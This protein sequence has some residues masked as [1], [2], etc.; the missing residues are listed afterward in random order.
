MPSKHRAKKMSQIKIL[1]SFFIMFINFGAEISDVNVVKQERY[2]KLQPPCE[3]VPPKTSKYDIE[4]WDFLL[5][6]S[7][8]LNSVSDF[9]NC[10]T[11]QSVCI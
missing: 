6:H 5:S 3:T 9:G 1:F 11:L 4:F 7:Q 8:N 2:T 10:P